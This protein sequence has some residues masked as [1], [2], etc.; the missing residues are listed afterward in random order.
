VHA[1]PIAKALHT[2]EL[3]HCSS[4]VSLEVKCAAGNEGGQMKPSKTEIGA[5]V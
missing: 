2:H 5:S 4:K 1:V 3:V